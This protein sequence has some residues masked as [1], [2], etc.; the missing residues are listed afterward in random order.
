MVW[1]KCP[2]KSYLGDAL[3]RIAGIEAVHVD[4]LDIEG[5]T[6]DGKLKLRDWDEKKTL[7]ADAYNLE[8]HPQG[9]FHGEWQAIL[10]NRL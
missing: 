1:L 7:I 5:Q 6:A 4:Y 9:L 10:L 2:G 3:A 8:K